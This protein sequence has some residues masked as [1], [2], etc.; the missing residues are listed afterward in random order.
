MPNTQV[1]KS[2]CGGSTTIITS[3]K[4]VLKIHVDLFKAAG[5]FV[6]DQYANS[7]LF[8]TRKEGLI[9]TTNFGNSKF[10]IRCSGSNCTQLTNQF[11]AILSQIEN[12]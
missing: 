7:G 2:C 11:E 5:F 1:L 10:H 9:A 4:P 3:T 6:N 12:S 8:Y